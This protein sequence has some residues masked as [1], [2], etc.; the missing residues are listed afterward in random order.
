MPPSIDRARFTVHSTAQPTDDD[1][2]DLI[3]QARAG[4]HDAFGRFVDA[5][6]GAIRAFVRRRIQGDREAVEEITAEV[7]LGAWRGLRT[8]RR[9]TNSPMAWLRTIAQRRVVDHHRSGQ[10][11]HAAIPAGTPDDLAMLRAA[12]GVGGAPLVDEATETYCVARD[13]ARAVWSHA[14]QLTADQYR[15]LRCR[16]FLGWSMEA[17]AAALGKPVASVKS[18][19]HRAV[20]RLREQ[21]AGSELDPAAR[22]TLSAA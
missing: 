15:V 19:Q 18:L 16:F 5:T 2:W 21:L 14:E 11:R 1:L 3:D 4:D 6:V 12:T 13:N 10:Q 9:L 17:T 8:L 7:Y 22:R 20:R